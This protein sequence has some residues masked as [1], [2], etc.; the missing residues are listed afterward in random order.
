MALVR[1]RYDDYLKLSAE[2]VE[3]A[4]EALAGWPNEPEDAPVFPSFVHAMC[5][6]QTERLRAARLLADAS[7]GHHSTSLV[8]MTYEETAW[9][10]YL[11]DLGD[12]GKQQRLLYTLRAANLRQLVEAQERLHAVKLS[13]DDGF[14]PAVFDE[15]RAQMPGIDDAVIELAAELGWRRSKP[16]RAPSL[17]WIAHKRLSADVPAYSLLAEAS[18]QLFHFSPHHVMKTVLRGDDGHAKH[19]SPQSNRQESE[20]A[21][22]WGAYLVAQSFMYARDWF[23]P[24]LDFDQHRDYDSWAWRM[25]RLIEHMEKTIG[26]PPLIHAHTLVREGQE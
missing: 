11:H 15:L 4:E 5:L 8:R 10:L 3:I 18:S 1:N 16:Q 2:V 14:T 21:L 17:S 19:G 26:L 23:A 24:I 7:L 9:C 20:F 22:G 13:L 12:D 6:R 25:H